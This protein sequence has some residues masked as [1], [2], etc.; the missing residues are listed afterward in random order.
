MGRTACQGGW[1]IWFWYPKETYS[2]E[3]EEYLVDGNASCQYALKARE[4]KGALH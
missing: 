2:Y 3:H 4:D 1:S